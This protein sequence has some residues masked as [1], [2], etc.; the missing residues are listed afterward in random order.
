M[1][2]WVGFVSRNVYLEMDKF[3]K[4][5][6]RGQRAS[7]GVEK[8]FEIKIVLPENLK[9]KGLELGKTYV[10]NDSAGI[11]NVLMVYVIFNK[12]YSGTLKSKV[13]DANQLEMGR[14]TAPV[15]A[16]KDEAMFIEFHFDKRT[17]IDRRIR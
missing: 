9:K 1:A 8:A 2:N 14:A 15:V 3:F 7:K 17:N 11:D 13:F 6:I 5:Y 12:P 4:E 10:T 16:K